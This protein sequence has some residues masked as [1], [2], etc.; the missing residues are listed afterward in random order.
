MPIISS[1]LAFNFTIILTITLLRTGVTGGSILGRKFVEERTVTLTERGYEPERIRLRRGVPAR[2][3]FI[4]QVEATCATEIE[5]LG[6]GIKRD[7][8]LNQPVVVEFTPTRSG[9]LTYTCSMKMVGGKI[10][11]R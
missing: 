10:L 11:I 5:L 3:T 6:Y 7:L 4:R 2:L 8:P 9:E 1:V